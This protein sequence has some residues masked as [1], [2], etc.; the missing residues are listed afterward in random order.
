[1]NYLVGK[2]HPRVVASEQDW[3]MM[4]T[5]LEFESARLDTYIAST[6]RMRKLAAEQHIDVLIS[7]HSGF[8]QAPAKLAALR[9]AP[10]GP[11][12]FVLGEPTVERALTVM[13]ECAQAQRDRFKMMAK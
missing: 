8:D 11:N 6:E 7:N 9:K 10:R 3:T 13:G 12:P 2:Y 4:E 5:K 1:M